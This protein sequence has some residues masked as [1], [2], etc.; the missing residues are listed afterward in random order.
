M[1]ALPVQPK[2]YHITH[3]DNLPAILVDGGLVSDAEMIRRG[4]P[5]AA[6]GMSSGDKAGM[7]LLRR[8]E[9]P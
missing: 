6:I 2:I 5:A 8:E 1:I 9:T 3:V 7:V 4:G